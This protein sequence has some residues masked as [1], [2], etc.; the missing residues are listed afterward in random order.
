M[1]IFSFS[2]DTDWAHEEIIHDALKL[3][4]EFSIKCT[5]F[6]TN[7]TEHLNT[8]SHELALHPNFSDI[9]SLEDTIADISINLPESIGIR[10]HTLFYTARLLPLYAKY[11]IRYDSN[12]V[13]YNMASVQPYRLTTSIWELPIFFMDN[14]HFWMNPFQDASFLFDPNTLNL[15]TDG[16]KVFVFHPIHIYLNTDKMERY[17]NIKTIYKNPT[18]LKRF[19]NPESSGKGVRVFLKRLLALVQERNW[20]VKTHA[21]II[22]L[23]RENTRRKE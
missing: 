2:I 15:E 3:F 6:L 13:M 11:G 4:D 12:V 19:I 18:K 7:G 14:I 17:E 23:A 8:G 9:N 10:S 22:E 16:I 5:L 21:E 1:K 20:E